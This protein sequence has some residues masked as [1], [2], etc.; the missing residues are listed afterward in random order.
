MQKIHSLTL[1]LL[2]TAITL[3]ATADDRSDA[4]IGAGL[5]GA[6]GAVIGY[7]A[8]GRDGAILGGAIGSASG[9]AVATDPDRYHDDRRYRVR[10]DHRRGH[11]GRGFCPPGL[12]KQGRC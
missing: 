6:L 2:L 8:G 11:R 4:A 3:P 5:G 1:A 7:E 10:D 9:V 12:A